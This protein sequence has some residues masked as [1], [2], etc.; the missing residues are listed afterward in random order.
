MFDNIFGAIDHNNM[1]HAQC[2]NANCEDERCEEGGVNIVF[3]TLIKYVD[4]ILV[5]RS[6]CCNDTY[7][8][9]CLYAKRSVESDTISK[10]S[11][12]PSDLELTLGS[13]IHFKDYNHDGVAVSGGAEI[14][15]YARNFTLKWEKPQCAQIAELYIDY[16]GKWFCEFLP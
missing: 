15:I 9:V 16:K 2:E 5:T 7:K 12:T 3:K 8:N 6:D 1:Y 14:E 13:E 11:C 10:I 4:L